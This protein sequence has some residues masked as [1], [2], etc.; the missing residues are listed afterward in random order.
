MKGYART[1]WVIPMLSAAVI[2]ILPV[3]EGTSS[4]TSTSTTP[5]PP[6]MSAVQHI[7]FLAEETAASITILENST[8]TE[9]R[10][11]SICRARLMVCGR[12]QR[13]K[14]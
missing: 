12:L 8:I 4:S 5:P 2:I 9:A 14:F 1:Q 13:H 7:V 3:A 11:R 10:L 6:G